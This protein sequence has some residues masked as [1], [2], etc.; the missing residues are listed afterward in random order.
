[1]ENYSFLINA[2]EA[3]YNTI[4]EL[5]NK[6]IPILKDISVKIKEESLNGNWKIDFDL[7]KYNLEN[8]YIKRIIKILNK[9]EYKTKE[10]SNNINI[11]II[12]INWM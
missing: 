3:K 9:Y 6:I 7:F 5:N 10:Y 12:E 11:T 2:S 4:N 8:K 1:M